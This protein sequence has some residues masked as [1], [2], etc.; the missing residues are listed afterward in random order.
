MFHYYLSHPTPIS[1]YMVFLDIVC[2]TVNRCNTNP[3]GQL[4]KII[5]NVIAHRVCGTKLGTPV[6]ETCLKIY[7]LVKV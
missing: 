4:Q 7:L 1:Q 5:F 6:A 2:N 3:T